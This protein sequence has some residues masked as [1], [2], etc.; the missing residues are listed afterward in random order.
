MN[1]LIRTEKLSK[2][3]PNGTF[4]NKSIDFQVAE[5]EIHGLVGENGAG[6]TTLMKMLYGEEQPSA[7]RIL[8]DEKPVTIASEFEAI[9]AGIG[10]VHQHFMLVPSLSAAENLVLGKEPKRTRSRTFDMQEAVRITEELSAR[11][12]LPVYARARVADLSVSMRQKLEIL[13]ALY[14]GARILILDEPTAVLTPQET[15][16]LF[17]ELKALRQRGKTIIFI[18]HKLKEIFNL[19]DRV[20]VMRDGRLIATH[21]VADVDIHQIS[22]EMVGREVQF[23]ISRPPLQAKSPAL[24]VRD[25]SFVDD[26]GIAKL[27]H[28]SFTLRHNEILGVVGVD[29]N[30]QTELVEILTG[31]EKPLS[32]SVMANGKEITGRSPGFIRR[33]G[34]AHIAEDRITVGTAL[35]ATISQNLL[36]DR[37]WRAQFC[38]PTG[39]LKMPAM[40]AEADRLV[41]DYDIRCNSPNQPVASLS[42]GNMQKVVVAREFTAEASILVIAQ[43]TRGVDIGAIEYIHARIMDMRSA[44]K[45]ILLVSS[46]LQEVMALS[47][48]LIVMHEGEIV[49]YFPD[50]SAVTDKELGLYMLGIRRQSDDELRKVLHEHD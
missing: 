15:E 41:K 20:T 32:G 31:T 44:G 8:I 2:I 43:P 6:K 39:F 10:M 49:A 11:Y 13:K 37:Y 36:A 3:Y 19:C 33:C 1:Y 34:V 5:G 17:A 14:R 12:N 16:E 46:D 48:S 42:G 27:K 25:I 40:A 35:P 22:N 30:G 45:A 7:G 29:G 26:F 50:A 18:S 23:E 38:A 21:Q 47:D 9:K 4:A 24:V 28:V